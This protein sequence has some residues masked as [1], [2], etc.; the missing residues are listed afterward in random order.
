MTRIL[1]VVTDGI[2][3]VEHASNRVLLTNQQAS[4]V[5]G[6]PAEEL[7]GLKLNEL[8][9]G[10]QGKAFDSLREQVAACKG[11]RTV[12]FR[13]EPCGKDGRVL[14]LLVSLGRGTFSGK[15]VF[16]LHITD[17]QAENKDEAILHE[18]L[19]RYR[20]FFDQSRDIILIHDEAGRLFNANQTAL[21]L[22]GNSLQ[23]I[24]Q[25][26]LQDLL[27]P[28]FQSR[29]RAYI[30]GLKKQKEARFDSLLLSS[31]GVSIPVE[32]VSGYV[33]FFDQ[34]LIMAVMRDM[35]E[36]VENE[37][38]LEEA[39]K[40]LELVINNIPQ[41]IFWKDLDLNYLGSNRWFALDAGLSSSRE[42]AGKNDLEL[43]WK[44][45]AEQYRKDD[46][47]VIR[48]GKP[49]LGY[50]EPQT[51]P[52]GE[53]L[54]LRTNK[55]PITNEKGEI[56]GVLG[57]YENITREKKMA[58]ELRLSEERWK[59]ALEGSGDGVWDWNLQT[60]EVF[61]SPRWKE[62][63]G[64]SEEEIPNHLSS[65]EQLI[66]P[67]DRDWV[68][69]ELR[70]HLDGKDPYYATEHRVLT[71]SGDY[72]WILDRG[73]VVEWDAEGNPLRMIGTHSDIH[74]L[75]ETQLALEYREQQL[76]MAMEAA[77]YYPFFYSR[78]DQKLVLS[79]H[80][81]EDQGYTGNELP[82]DA[83]S[84]FEQVHPGDV[85]PFQRLMDDPEGKQDQPINIEF[86][87]RNARGDYRWFGL[88]GRRMVFRS[89]KKEQGVVGLLTDIT[90]RKEAEQAILQVNEEL[91]K[92]VNRRTAEMQE[93]YKELESFSYSISHDLRA[94]LRHIDGFAS[95]LRD[96]SLESLDETSRQYL[97]NICESAQRMGKLI[98]DLL[99]FSRVG[100][101]EIRLI[102]FDLDLLF[103]EV[104]NEYLPE[105]KDRNIEWKREPLGKVTADPNLLRQVVY[106]LVS[107]A[108]KYTS[109]RGQAVVSIGKKE[110]KGERVFYIRDNGVG[111]RSKYAEKIFGV[112]QR[113]HLNDE[114]EG[115][116]I[117]LAN[118][119]KI[120]SRHGGR[121]WAEG[122]EDEGACF[123]FS[124]PETTEKN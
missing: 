44:K 29:F 28:G 55:I 25:K 61:F 62:M 21:D 49:K 75:K 43:G 111:F 67:G 31:K 34:P 24:R 85:K 88:S 7:E 14:K 51:T 59:F 41:R 66:H 42:I 47:E 64:Y 76:K 57:T 110:E 101:S 69:K 113:L 40:N 54:W 121:I 90:A 26:S 89:G 16:I 17:L 36:K 72:R 58:E 94:P 80:F 99:Q 23:E 79:E 105:I 70:K 56:T 48:T 103:D 5:F 84:F 12:R 71:K 45:E 82:P 96:R 19:E 22:T 4:L 52:Y 8:C 2:L 81:A 92:R 53:T 120:I 30:S 68:Y 115:T 108:I 27:G 10:K 119:R 123:F 50:E 116:G 13:W 38:K 107:N 60:N 9:R 102:E 109:T 63:L 32:A 3:I 73:K 39:R 91:E 124:L 104:I 1:N 114:F 35:S 97:V 65:W 78:K 77:K 37:R 33:D 118:A 98:E 93:A 18:S 74:S 20:S 122:K 46:R 100:R 87:F 86:K 11:N 112:F 106:N 117:G 6:Y 15:E 95:M 83:R